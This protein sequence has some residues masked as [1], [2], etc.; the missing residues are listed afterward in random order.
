M[1]IQIYA[2]FVCPYC[3]AGEKELMDAVKEINPSIEVEMMSYELAPGATDNNNLKM[4][5][6]LEKKFGLS[7]E[8]IKKNNIKVN[9]M[10]HDA[11]LDINS[12]DIKFSNTLKA[13]TLLQYAKEK[14]LANDL[15]REIYHSYFVEGSYLNKIDTLIEIASKVGIDKETVK[16]V[17][18]SKEFINKVHNERSMGKNIGVRP[19]PHVIIDGEISLSGAQSKKNY[20][21][22]INKAISS[23]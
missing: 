1:K 9:K 19:I 23:K 15:S 10:V 11:G 8:D 5:D 3:Y 12:D 16:E 14:D 22:A 6:V 7:P 13:H 2:D 17:I 4:S 20:K 21:D 18:V